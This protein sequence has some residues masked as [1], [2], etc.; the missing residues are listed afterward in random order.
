MLARENA[1]QL[2]KI[3]SSKVESL[4]AENRRLRATNI[5]VDAL[6]Q[7]IKESTGLHTQDLEL[8]QA[9]VAE[10]DAVIHALERR[11]A[12]EREAFK[13][14]V[15]AN[16]E[17]TCQLH[18]ILIK[19]QKGKFVDADTAHS[20]E[21]LQK[22]NTHLLHINRVLRS[23]VILAGMDPEILVLVVQGMTAGEL[24]LADLELD[25]ET[26][27][28]LQRIQAAAADLS[29]PH[30][31]PAALAKAAHQ[32]A[33]G[34]LH[35]RIRPGGADSDNDIGVDPDSY[36]E[37]K[38]PIPT[39]QASSAMSAAGLGDDATAENSSLT[40]GRRGLHKPKAWKQKKRQK[41]RPGSQS[42]VRSRSSQSSRHTSPR[43]QPRSRSPSPTRSSTGRPRSRSQSVSS[44]RATPVSSPPS[45][46]QASHSA[47]KVLKDDC[48]PE[49][50]DLTSD[51]EMS[52]SPE[53]SPWQHRALRRTREI[54]FPLLQE[55]KLFLKLLHP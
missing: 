49:L 6:L 50:I 4:E 21:D 48:P 30:A 36:S 26:F 24:N 32:V 15:A 31:V 39:D 44:K 18:A 20:L 37:D 55:V 47:S 27:V 17:Q 11:L 46:V 33:H 38:P 1:E 14:A 3:L 8:A 51:V 40:S 42:S 25:Q 12:T 22:R 19:A 35:K 13:A 43:S 10:R 34:K 41:T 28:A 23:H 16:T 52:S 5:R 29:D 9:E 53:D 2:L 54:L 45:S 7:K